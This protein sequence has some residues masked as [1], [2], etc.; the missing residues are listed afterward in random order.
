MRAQKAY[1]SG[2]VNVPSPKVGVEVNVG[3]DD[4][5]HKEVDCISK[6]PSLRDRRRVAPNPS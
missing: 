2:R 6:Q 1:L 4:S 3:V 5:P